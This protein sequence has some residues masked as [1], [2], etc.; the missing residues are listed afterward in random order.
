MPVLLRTLLILFIGMIV[1]WREEKVLAIGK[2]HVQAEK[3]D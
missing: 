1:H 3:R 2:L